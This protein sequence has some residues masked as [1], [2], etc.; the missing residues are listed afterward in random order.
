MAA[1]LG[2]DV[3]GGDLG[4]V[5][6]VGLVAVGYAAGPLLAARYFRSLSSLALAAVS[7]ALVAVAYAP[8]ALV[9]HPPEVPGPGSSPPWW[10]WA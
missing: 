1:L 7:V 10:R 8:V 4:A 2:L 3:G 5:G 6:E 9:Q